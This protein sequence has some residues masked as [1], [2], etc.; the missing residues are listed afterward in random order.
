MQYNQCY[1]EIAII[2]M[3]KFGMV[4]YIPKARQS[5]QL[6]S[7]YGPISLL[8]FLNKVTD[9]IILR[10]LKEF[11]DNNIFLL[12]IQHSFWRRH[13]FSHQIRCV[14]KHIADNI[15]ERRQMAVIVL[16]I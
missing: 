10:K 2:L 16:D 1:D 8:P 4:I 11:T 15:N 9:R 5:L 12:D 6:L 7:S 14:G 13:G 3:C